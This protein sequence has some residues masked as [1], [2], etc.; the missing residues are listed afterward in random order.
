MPAAL[1]LGLRIAVDDGVELRPLRLE[2]A[3]PAYVLVEA[4][5]ARLAEW[6]PWVPSIK[7]AADE[8]AFIRGTHETL[9]TGT[10]LS[11]ALIVDRQL[12]GTMGCSIN[13]QSRSAE[14]GYWI[15]AGHEGRGLITRG[16]RALT[17]FLVT[18]LGLHRVVIRA[19]TANLRSRAVPERLGFTHEGTQ[20]HAEILNDEFFDLEVYSMLAPEWPTN[21]A[22]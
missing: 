18:D 17:T 9:E 13:P 15:D 11:C 3:E 2:D 16:V 5:R 14:I 6:L 22:H 4:N 7:S 12:A 1:H 21:G 10:G 20:R 19:A 8:A